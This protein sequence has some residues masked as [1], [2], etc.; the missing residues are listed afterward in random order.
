MSGIRSTITG[1]G[2]LR[3]TLAAAFV[4]AA[5]TAGVSGAARASGAAAPALAAK[6][7][8]TASPGSSVP[9]FLL[10]RGRFLPVAIPRGL[11]DLAPGGISPIKIN[12]RGQIVGSYLSPAGAERGF[13]LDR[14]RNR[15]TTA[16]VPRAM[17]TQAQGIN[18]RGQ[19]VGVYSDTSNPSVTGAQLRGFLL[20]AGRYIRLDFPG[21]TSSQAYDIN[22]QG[23]VVGEYQA[24]DGTF[25]GYLWH[26]GRFRALPTGG[27]TG[28]NNHGQIT[29]TIGDAATLHGFVLT[30]N[31]VTTF[32]APGAPVTFPFDINDRGQIVGL[33]TSGPTATTASGFLRSHGR[34]TAINRPGAAFTAP[35]GIN[36]RGQ[37]VGIGPSPQDLASQPG[38]AT[39]P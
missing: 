10:E 38:P 30:G 13:L 28:I 12:D 7:A 4:L 19:I 32:E 39:A 2:R 31:R 16:D 9:G 22:D 8:S 1:R 33:S 20:D 36:D 18:N 25:H 14:N 21:A 6:L 11:E 26:R 24:A 3:V 5:L 17:G 34:F 15:F 27:A 29:G 35:F 37:I 23:Q